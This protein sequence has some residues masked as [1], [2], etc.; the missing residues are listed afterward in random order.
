MSVPVPSIKVSL[1]G[2]IHFDDVQ[3]YVKILPEMLTVHKA[4]RTDE[5]V[6]FR[7]CGNAI[8]M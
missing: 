8:E 7:D 2:K 6:T 1:P 4:F 3:M 5:N